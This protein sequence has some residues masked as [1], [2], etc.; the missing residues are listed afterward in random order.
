MS[1]ECFE[2]L[3]R[4]LEPGAAE[5]ASKS[6]VTFNRSD[7]GRVTVYCGEETPYG[8]GTARYDEASNTIIVGEKEDY[9]IHLQIVL[10]PI[11]PGPVAGSWTA[12]D[13]VP[14]FEPG[15]GDE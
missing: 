7:D 12:E 11:K 15:P 4:V 6:I 13:Y 5:C 8:K 14:G 3:W 9:V 10:R 2:R 1:Y